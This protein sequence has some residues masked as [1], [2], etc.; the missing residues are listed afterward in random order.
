MADF[1]AE[2]LAQRAYDFN[3]LTNQQLEEVWGA[4]GTRDVPLEAFERLTVRKELLTN[5]QSDRIKEGKR[6]GYYYGKYK[7]LYMVGSGTFA[8]VYRA[9]HAIDDQVVAIK[10]LRQRYTED[11]ETRENFLREAKVVIPLRHI[12]IVPIFDDIIGTGVDFLDVD[13]QVPAKMALD[14]T[15]G[16]V[17][18]RGNLD[19]SSVFRFGT[20]AHVRAE[21]AA[22]CQDVGD[23]AGWVMCSG[24]D[25]P[26]GTS[27]ENIAAFVE[28]VK[29]T[30][31]TLNVSG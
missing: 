19:P 9:A 5:F 30:S 12:N 2:K 10:V 14:V 21:T 24:C 11:D 25:I 16:R 8:R 31:K 3:L 29:A 22:L 7:L 17:A 6:D 26:P 1:T 23:H 27:A 13:Y 4:L 28:V 18:L 20:E 15:Q